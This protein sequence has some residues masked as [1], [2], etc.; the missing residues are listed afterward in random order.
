MH[1]DI[2]PPCP[3]GAAVTGGGTGGCGV[4][5]TRLD[6]ELVETAV[7]DRAVVV[8]QKQHIPIQR[9]LWVANGLGETAGHKPLHRLHIHHLHYSKFVVVDASPASSHHQVFLRGSGSRAHPLGGHAGRE[10]LPLLP[11]SQPVGA[12]TLKGIRGAMC[13]VDVGAPTNGGQSVVDNGHGKAEI[14][15]ARIHNHPFVFW[16]CVLEDAV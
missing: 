6:E 1:G 8:A 11:S 4:W 15:T 12:Q 14:L 10:F 9:H 13:C 16:Q 2:G 3:H 7:E 5:P